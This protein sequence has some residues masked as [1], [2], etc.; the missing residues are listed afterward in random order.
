VGGVSGRSHWF[1]LEHEARWEEAEDAHWEPLESDGRD[2]GRGYSHPS[3]DRGGLGKRSEQCDCG[4]G[5]GLQLF[6][7]V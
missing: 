1:W 2:G 5:P 4:L 3:K 6:T 7:R